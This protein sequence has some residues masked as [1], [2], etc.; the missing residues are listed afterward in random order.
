M[1]RA[2]SRTMDLDKQR[3][4]LGH[5]SDLFPGGV[6]IGLAILPVE[7]ESSGCSRA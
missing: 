3:S 4:R 6:S 2:Q 1:A 7:S 5:S